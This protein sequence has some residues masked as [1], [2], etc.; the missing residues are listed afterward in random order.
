MPRIG[1]LFVLRTDASGV[2]VS[3]CL[4]QLD[5]DNEDNVVVTGV[6]EKPIAFL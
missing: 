1:G 2:A 4:Y 6:G 5:N 3:G